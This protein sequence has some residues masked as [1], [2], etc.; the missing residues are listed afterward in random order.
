MRKLRKLEDFAVNEGQLKFC[1]KK[2]INI[3][4]ILSRYYNGVGNGAFIEECIFGKCQFDKC[5]K[6]YFAKIDPNQF[7]ESIF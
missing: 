4:L 7:L 1:V 5:K 6:F 3:L 2:A